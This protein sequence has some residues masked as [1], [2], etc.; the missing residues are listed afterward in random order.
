MLCQLLC[1]HLSE[2]RRKIQLSLGLAPYL[3][4]CDSGGDRDH[5]QFS[6]GALDD[7]QLSDDG[8]DASHRGQGQGAIFDD[9]RLT[10]LVAVLHGYDDALCPADYVHGA[11]HAV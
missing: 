8:V 4:L 9:L 6:R 3:L 2:V 11:A 1:Q 10:G 7:A 5:C